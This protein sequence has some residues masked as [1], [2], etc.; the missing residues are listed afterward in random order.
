MQALEL[1]DDV[2]Y[3]VLLRASDAG[4]TPSPFLRR[5]LNGPN[6]ATL[7][8]GVP[9][10]PEPVSRK[11]EVGARSR[12]KEADELDAFLQTPAFLVHSD[13]IGRFVELLGFIYKKNLNKFD[14]VLGISGE[15]R[16]YFTKSRREMED[17]GRSV[18]PKE[19]P[20]SPFLVV[21]NTST[22]MKQEILRKV[23]QILGYPQDA[24]SIAERAIQRR[25]P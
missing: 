23:L 7:S 1:E 2:Y 24:I 14:S 5:Q 25:M 8:G 21:G 10:S 19:I 13:V 12:S 18:M 3:L 17:S 20:G 11:T 6:S 9:R 4:L 16:K 22:S 15:S